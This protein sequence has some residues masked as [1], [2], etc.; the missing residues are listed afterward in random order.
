MVLILGQWNTMDREHWQ[1][2]Q[3]LTKNT[4]RLWLM[5]WWFNKTFLYRQAKN[6]QFLAQDEIQSYHWSKEYCKFYIPWLYT[7]W[8]QMVA[9]NM[10]NCVLFLMTTTVLEGSRKTR[11]TLWIYIFI[12]IIFVLVLNGF[13]YN[14]LLQ[15]YLR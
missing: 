1:L 7:T 3:L 4:K 15:M 12:S 10:I 6:Y 11:R 5:F 13:F 14:K 8:D 9:S 2:L